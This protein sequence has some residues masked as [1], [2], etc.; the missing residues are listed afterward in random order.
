MDGWSGLGAYKYPCLG[1]TGLLALAC[2]ILFAW[3]L[4]SWQPNRSVFLSENMWLVVA[5]S[6]VCGWSVAVVLGLL[7]CPIPL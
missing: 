7:T 3:L 6:I 5:G 1:G 2:F 4:V